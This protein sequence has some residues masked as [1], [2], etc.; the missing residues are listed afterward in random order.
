M[1]EAYGALR[2]VLCYALLPK[3]KLAD[4][5]ERPKRLINTRRHKWRVWR[6]GCVLQRNPV[7]R[8]AQTLAHFI[9]WAVEL[10]A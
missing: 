1:G 7:C 6:E 4:I 5:C 2:S 10:R 8:A 9:D 3:H